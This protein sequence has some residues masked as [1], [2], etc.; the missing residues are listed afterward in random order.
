MLSKPTVIYE[1]A[2]FLI[3]NKPSGLQVHPARIAERKRR[4]GEDGEKI[5]NALTLV[6]WLLEHYPEVKTVGDDLAARPGIV[7]RLD[8]E[9]SGIMIVPRNQ[10]TFGEL[11]A[12]FQEH[13]IQK[14]YLA[15]VAGALPKK[16]GVIDAPIGIKNGT[17]KRSVHATKM[18]KPAVT[19]YKVIKEFEKSA[20]EQDGSKLYSLVEVKPQTGRTHQIRVHLASIGHPIVGDTL[21][22]KKSQPAFARRLMLHAQSLEF[23]DGRGNHFSFEAAPP[24][25]FR[26]AAEISTG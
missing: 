14:T 3:L 8:K 26:N 21:Y 2:D 19:E 15:L 12:L 11:K 6:D 7:H 4:R 24:D 25:D 10:K 22:G 1:N 5:A 16:E 13:K 23:E 9:T 20:N 17:L 18:L